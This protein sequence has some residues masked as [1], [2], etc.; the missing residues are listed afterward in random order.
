MLR[1]TIELV[2][3]GRESGAQVIGRGYIANTS[4][5][6]D[7]S[8][9]VLKFEEDTWRGRVRG[10]Y[11]GTLANWPRNDKGAWEIVCAALN[12]VMPPLQAPKCRKLANGR[13]VYKAR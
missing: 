5:L 3:G 12:M 11:A 6:R 2:P 1:I 4:N 8:N 7:L 10:P 13:P 9:Y